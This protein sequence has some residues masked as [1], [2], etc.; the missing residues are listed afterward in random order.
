M[1]CDLSAASAAGSGSASFASASFS[2]ASDS[3]GV[4]RPVACASCASDD[5]DSFFED[6]VFFVFEDAAFF[7]DSVDSPISASHH[8]PEDLCLE[9]CAGCAA[10]A[11]CLAPSWNTP[12]GASAVPW[13]APD[14]ARPASARP[15]TRDP[16][17]AS[18]AKDP[19]VGFD[20]RSLSGAWRSVCFS[21]ALVAATISADGS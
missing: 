7:E 1:S 20:P 17:T 2:G 16:A 5:E 21:S 11:V 19:R 8:L 15:A 14:E 6:S 3:W 13:T 10:C 4:T 9:A 18:R 12:A